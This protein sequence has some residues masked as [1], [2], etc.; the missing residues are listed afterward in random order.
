MK[1]RGYQFSREQTHLANQVRERAC[2]EM[3]LQQRRNRRYC[4]ANDY[5]Q[6]N[7]RTFRHEDILTPPEFLSSPGKRANLP[8]SYWNEPFRFEDLLSTK[9]RLASACSPPMGMKN[10]TDADSLILNRLRSVFRR[11][12]P[13]VGSWC[14]R[15]NLGLAR[16]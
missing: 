13:F 5:S 16:P 2:L 14:G 8:S 1:E 4:T 9:G 12:I 3:G 15:A 6:H 7:S 11:S 10:T